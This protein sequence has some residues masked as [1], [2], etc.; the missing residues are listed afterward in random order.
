MV[1]SGAKIARK[2]KAGQ[3]VVI[4]IHEQGERIPLTI[5]DADPAKGTVT[6]IFQVCGKST[7]HLSDLNVGDE[8][9]DLV[10][11]LGKP[12]HVEKIGTVACIGGGIGVAP[13]YPITQAMKQA[14][15]RI[16]SI[17]GARNKELLIMEDEMK[18]V[19]DE[20]VVTT[21]D[22]SYGFHGF[23]SQALENNY[24]MKGI[25]IDLVVAIGPVPMMRAVC[26]ITR[27]YNVPTVVSL[28]SIMVDATGMCG[29]CRVSVGGK[30]R[31]ACVEGPEFDGHQVDFKELIDR[32]R[33][34]L[35]DEKECMDHYCSCK[36]G[37]GST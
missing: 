14:G 25:K 34:Y 15:N 7:S 36:L 4:R 5:A 33:I 6:I 2:R 20:I 37:K 10:G 28:N 16:I 32:Q 18:A 13:V 24:L 30:T 12:T 29:A 27:K 1:L 22:G 35:A 11:P 8:I 23:V 19:S 31:F 21:D 17:I 3:F 26:D 9:L